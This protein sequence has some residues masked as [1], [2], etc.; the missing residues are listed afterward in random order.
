AALGV[1]PKTATGVAD[2]NDYEQYLYDPNGNR[3]QLRKRDGKI[4]GY[5]YDALNRLSIKYMPAPFPT[6]R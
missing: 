4:I 1:P 6:V 5:D 2:Q 3:V